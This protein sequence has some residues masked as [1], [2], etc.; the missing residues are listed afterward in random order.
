MLFL[1]GSQGKDMKDNIICIRWKEFF[2]IAF[3]GI[4]AFIFLLKSP[5][6]PWVSSYSATDSSVFQTVAMMM[7]KGYM[8]YRNSFD[9]KG[10]LT[11]IINYVGRLLSKESGIWFLEYISLVGT[12]FIM[13]KITRIFRINLLQSIIAVFM[14]FS[15]LF[16]YFDGGNL[17]EKWAM[18]FIAIG[19]YIF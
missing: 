19:I 8:P 5:L 6:H 11:Y 13:Y 2:I 4:L 17:V 14:G 15:L 12:C 1:T 3:F 7:E 18:P 16:E 9:H 10:P